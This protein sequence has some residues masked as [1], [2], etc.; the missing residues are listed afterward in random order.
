MTDT[1]LAAAIGWVLRVGVT[2]SGLL[3]AIGF[4]SSFLVGW[5]G[6]LSGAEAEPPG[7]TSFEGLLA[8]LAALRPIA[9]A[10]LG[11]LLLVLTPVVR[12]A[13]SAIGFA[14]E[15]DGLYVAITL[16]VL[17]ILASSLLLF[18]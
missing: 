2:L 12:V 13:V 7:G 16:T 11:L 5:D 6:S 9:I 18:R 4:L 15:R 10:E 17:A 14:R 3:I 1:R 8:G